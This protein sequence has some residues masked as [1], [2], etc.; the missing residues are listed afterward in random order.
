MITARDAR[1]R[2]DDSK[3]TRVY[4]AI[5]DRATE[6]HY[7]TE[8]ESHLVDDAVRQR[9]EDLGFTIEKTHRLRYHDEAGGFFVTVSWSKS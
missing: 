7:T 2:A 1:K 5:T 9:L 3:W 8:I 4:S 6:G